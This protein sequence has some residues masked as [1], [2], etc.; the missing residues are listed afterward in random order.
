MSL[1]RYYLF[2]YFFQ[3]SF[4]AVLEQFQSNSRTTLEQFQSTFRALFKKSLEHGN[5]CLVS[6]RLSLV[7][8]YLFTYFLLD[9][10]VNFPSNL[11][12]FRRNFSF[13]V[14]LFFLK[15]KFWFKTINCSRFCF[16]KCQNLGFNDYILV[17]RSLLVQILVF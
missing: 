11:W 9:E 15:I 6:A 13:E 3:S 12:V 7:R 16:S 17:T 14:T 10:K 5:F 4:R 1:V 8:H 2:T